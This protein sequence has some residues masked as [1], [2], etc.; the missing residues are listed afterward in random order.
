MYLVPVVLYYAAE[1]RNGHLR[2]SVLTGFARLQSA[3]SD[4]A[5]HTEDWSWARLLQVQL[6]VEELSVSFSWQGAKGDVDIINSAATVEPSVQ[7]QRG[8]TRRLEHAWRKKSEKRAVKVMVL[9]Q[10]E[11]MSARQ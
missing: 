5:V 10:T 6:C 3:A 11:N 7:A 4:S 1:K 2:L 9:E 8:L